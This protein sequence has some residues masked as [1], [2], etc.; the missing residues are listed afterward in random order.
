MA[1][2]RVFRVGPHIQAELEFI[3]AE[4]LVEEFTTQGG[5]GGQRVRCSVVRKEHGTQGL[6]CRAA[7]HL[8]AFGRVILAVVGAAMNQV[9]LQAFLR[10]VFSKTDETDLG[11]RVDQLVGANSAESHHAVLQPHTAGPGVI[12]MR[13]GAQALRQGRLGKLQQKSRRGFKRVI[14]D[15]IGLQ[16]EA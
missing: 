5:V 7:E 1:T 10:L 9:V 4:K 16:L 2:H 12:G 13:L 3:L 15:V 6:F 14:E 11:R 8:G